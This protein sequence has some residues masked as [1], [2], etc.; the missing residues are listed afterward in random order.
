MKTKTFLF[1]PAAA[2]LAALTFA[3]ALSAKDITLAECP[4]SVQ[5]AINQNLAGGTL[6]EVDLVSIQGQSL[7]VAEVKLPTAQRERKLYLNASGTVI[8]VRDD[9]ALSDAPAAVQDAAKKLASTTGRVDDVEKETAGDK[10]TYRV[11]ID[12]QD[13]DG[14]DIKAV[15]N[16]DGSIITQKAD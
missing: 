11:E 15:F 7:Y 3:P 4:A 14:G 2:L 5:Q 1:V 16:A 6:D 10:V 9:I 13:K 12:R 8:K